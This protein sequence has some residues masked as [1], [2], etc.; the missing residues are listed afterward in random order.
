MVLITIDEHY[1][2]VINILLYI[3]YHFEYILLGLMTNKKI[4][5]AVNRKI[6]FIQKVLYFKKIF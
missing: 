3:I 2:N 6:T 1:K 5:P 4:E